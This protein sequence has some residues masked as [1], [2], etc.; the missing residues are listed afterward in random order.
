M[1][2]AEYQAHLPTPIGPVS[3]G[4]FH[5]H[6]LCHQLLHTGKAAEPAGCAVLTGRQQAQGKHGKECCGM[7]A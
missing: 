3:V 6:P 2:C 7:H 5:G 1:L 4:F